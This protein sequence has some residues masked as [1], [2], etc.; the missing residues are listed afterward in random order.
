MIDPKVFV[1]L[2]VLSTAFI[3]A[4]I[5]GAVC[6][7]CRV[8]KKDSRRRLKDDY[9]IVLDVSFLWPFCHSPRHRLACA[10]FRRALAPG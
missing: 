3:V 4:A 5:V 10:H 1:A 2:L 7:L 9:V 6:F 8:L